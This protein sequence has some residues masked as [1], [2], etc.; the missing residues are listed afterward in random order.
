MSLAVYLRGCIVGFRT[1]LA[2]DVP[3]C[4]CGRERHESSAHWSLMMTKPPESG[5]GA[6]TRARCWSPPEGMS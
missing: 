3:Q 6:S 2:A 4:G 1:F 5:H